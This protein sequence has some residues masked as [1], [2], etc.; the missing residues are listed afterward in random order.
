MA[1]YTVKKGDTLSAIAKKYNTS[2]NELVKSNGI[3]NAN[4]IYSGQTLNIPGSSDTSSA[5]PTTTPT[6][7]PKSAASNTFEYKEHTP[8]A[9]VE[10]AKAALT[11]LA[12]PGGYQSAW[13]AQL[14]D[15]IN[16]IMNRDKFSYDLNGDALYQQYKDMYTTQG[17]QA[18]MDTMGQAAAMTGGY[19]NSYAQSVGQQTY[20]GYLQQL[21]DKVPELY[22]LALSQYNQEGQDLLNQYALL[23]EQENRDYGRHRDAV[24]D[25]LT[26]R[27]YLTDQY[28]AER[29]YDRSIYDSDR[30]YDYGVFS[31]QKAYDYQAERNKIEDEWKQKEFDEAVR[32]FNASQKKN[33]VSSGGTTKKTTNPTGDPAPTPQESK[34]DYAEWDALDWD[35]YFSNIRLS[36][37]KAAAEAELSR[38]NKAGYIP[39]QMIVIAA[40]GARGKLGR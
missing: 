2:V 12:N 22:Q 27:A 40:I 32:Q 14:T 36:E 34:A 5:A 24:S 23:G 38:M 1:S 31:D 19:G 35:K 37:G 39:K 21:N 8:S 29:Q 10:Q 33:S 17:K 20:Q 6:E 28:N 3:K 7:A 13:Q 4:L 30:A 9:S 11:N 25:Y 26:E 18:M 15:T 16:K